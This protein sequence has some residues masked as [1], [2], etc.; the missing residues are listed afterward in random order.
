MTQRP[1]EMLMEWLAKR[2][3]DARAAIAIDSDRLIS[4]A[5]LLG[6]PALVDP[7]GRS[8]QVAVF[9]GDDLAF[10]LRF[11][12][13]WAQPP[14]LIVLARGADGSAKIDVSYLTDILARN[15]AGPPL[16]LSV[17][18]FFRRICPQINFPVVHLRR[19]K[20]ALLERLD[21]VP[22]AASKIIQ[23]WGKPDDWGRGQVAALVLL[24]HHPD[25]TLS[26]IWPDETDPADFMAHALRVIL[27][28]PE[29]ARQR[30][31]VLEMV[32]EAARPQVHEQAHWL[33]VPPEELAAY[34]V[35]RR[36][37]EQ[38]KLQNPSTQLAGLHI[39][40]PETPLQSLE[41]LALKVAEK[42]RSDAR[43][44]RAVEAQAET[45][46][47]PRRLEK[48]FELVPA[49]EPALGVL[50]VLL[51]PDVS[52]AIAFRQLR[53]S[54]LAFFEKPSADRMAWASQLAAHPLLS[55]SADGLSASAAQYRAGLR[56]VVALDRV[57]SRLAKTMPRLPHADAVLD[58]YVENGQHLLELDV[59]QA[60]HDLEDCKDE[61]LTA[62]G[63]Q[64][65]FGGV[66]DLAPSPES[67]KGR[68]RARLNELDRALAE[69]VRKDSAA[70]ARGPRSALGLLEREVKGA[71]EGIISGS[72]PGRVWV[73]VFDGMRFDTWDAVVRPILA[74]HFAI[75]GKPCF[76][77]LPSYTQIARTS[78][79]AGCLPQEWKGYK[80]G[81]TKD[82]AVL[83]A[84]NLGLVPQDAK[85]KL[86]FVTEADTTKARMAMGASD[87]DAKEVNVLI[88]PIS[89]ECHE[90]RGDLAAFNSKIRTE[91]V[92]DK[93][94]GVRGILDDLL[95]RIR[96]EDTV[97]IVSDHGFTEMLSTDGVLVSEGEARNAGR[98]LQEDVHYRYAK[99]FRPAQSPDAVEVQPG[100]ETHFVVVGGHW[101]RREGAK[102][103]P[104]YWHGGLSLAEMVVPAVVLHRTTS[105]EARAELQ[106]LPVG[107]LRVQEDA[108]AELAFRVLNSGNTPVEF[109]VSARTNLGEELLSYKGKLGLGE[110]YKAKCS[111]V[112]RYRETPA[113]E[114]DALG[115]LT[116]IIV[117]LRHTDLHGE[118]REALDGLVTVPVGVEAKKFKID[119]DALRGF[120]SI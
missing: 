115:T 37:A 71:A 7:S 109:E 116:G 4:E 113:R 103:V 55:G 42:M 28:L 30:A 67:L 36:T 25:L 6:K 54:L 77:I 61:G 112:G 66:D 111:A 63:Q 26:H 95:R 51:R 68:V 56:L 5:G 92:G 83:V 100:A 98:S 99:G 44:W 10:R 120:D 43:T 81:P 38:V 53:A 18:A 9:R 41:P 20:D 90:Y 39:F 64:Y 105:K 89:D 17:P 29:L 21:N 35:L 93:T 88:Y 19:F 82:E 3:A 70:F 16:D 1:A 94:Q 72:A 34:L 80:G 104:R 110:T 23:R 12:K 65:L 58:W 85:S 73:L 74:E 91:I 32:H 79:F 108:T 50:P 15:E 11:R 14:V 76:C 84:R 40:S 69:F 49:A 46:L 75:Q 48:V 8:W 31:I 87:A 119:T 102:T 47:T 24:A 22:A 33:D 101:L 114:A 86:R 57:E 45:F 60:W 62:A 52:P 117:R 107:S 97:L 106:D 27:G 59:A 2:P 96:L 13:A 118:W 78:L